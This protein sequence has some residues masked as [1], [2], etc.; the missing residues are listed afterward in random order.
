MRKVLKQLEDEARKDPEKYKEKFFKEFG[1]FLKEGEEKRQNVERFFHGVC[2]CKWSSTICWSFLA[3][4]ID[5]YERKREDELA[6]LCKSI[7]T[8]FPAFCR[9]F[10]CASY[11]FSTTELLRRY[12]PRF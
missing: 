11:H 5:L 6:L 9:W 12:L 3:N 2:H 8:W 7:D 4:H 10:I 1:Y